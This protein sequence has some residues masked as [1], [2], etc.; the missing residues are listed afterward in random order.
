MDEDVL[1]VYSVMELEKGSTICEGELVY[2]WISAI[3]FFNIF[4]DENL[5]G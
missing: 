4:D 3:G 2:V 5:F 1:N